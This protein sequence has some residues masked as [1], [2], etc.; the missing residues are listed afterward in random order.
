[1]TQKLDSF[2][3]SPHR[4]FKSIHVAGTNGKGSVSNLLAASLQANGYKVGLYTSP[5][6]TDFRERIRI[7]GEMIPKADVIEFVNSWKD[8]DFE[9]SPSFFELTM[10]MAFDWFAK[11]NV[12]YAIIEVGMGG[13]LDSTNVISPVLSIIT[14][15][16][17]D[18]VQFLGDTLEKIAAE[19]AG[20]MKSHIPVVIGEASSELKDVFILKA[21]ET[22]APIIFAE[23]NTDIISAKHT[24]DG[25]S[26]ESQSYGRLTIPLHGDY[27]LMNINTALVALNNL[28]ESLVPLNDFKV[29]FGLEN[30]ASL[31]GFRGRWQIVKEH[32][33]IICDTGHNYSGLEYNI[34]QLERIQSSR[35]NACIFFVIGFVAD[36]DLDRIVRLFPKNATYF[37]TQADIPRALP[38]DDLKEI[39]AKEGFEGKVYHDVKSAA[40][41]A[42]DISNEEDIIY[43]GGS[44]FVVADYLAGMQ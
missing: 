43:I 2:F 35:A 42:I 28:K 30:V 24:V 13:R 33:L 3:G 27:Q 31:T 21:T 17:F 37:F 41:A 23:E 29:K 7:N 8:S 26:I 15:I 11:E 38:A 25:W 36:K 22:E 39:F 9:G 19:K 20:I 14:N 1:M 4:R 40:N 16:S 6:L 18:H 34:K 12:D 5:H 44:T 10:M 32:P